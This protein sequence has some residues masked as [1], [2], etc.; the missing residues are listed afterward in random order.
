M[1]RGWAL[2]LMYIKLTTFTTGYRTQNREYRIQ[3]LMYI[4]LPIDPVCNALMR[5]NPLFGQVSRGWT[6]EISNSK[7][8]QIAL[9]WRENNFPRGWGISVS[10][11]SI[12]PS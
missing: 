1:G 4:R 6:L 10:D 8:A 12:D 3:K 9:F 7:G 11:K 2:K 5:E